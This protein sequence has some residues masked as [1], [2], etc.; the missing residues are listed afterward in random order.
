[1]LIISRQGAKRHHAVFWLV[2]LFLFST[3]LGF[4]ANFEWPSRKPKNTTS[5]E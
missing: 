2:V 1:M 5:P 4:F 3:Q